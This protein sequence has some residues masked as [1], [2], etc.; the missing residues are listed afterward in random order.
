MD[1]KRF[2][3]KDLSVHGLNKFWCHPLNE[4]LATVNTGSRP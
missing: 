3:N 2:Y 4:D 1:P